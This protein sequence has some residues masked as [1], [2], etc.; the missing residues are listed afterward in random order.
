MQQVCIDTKR[1]IA[2]FVFR[3]RDL[4]QFSKFDQLRA[5]GQVPFTPR[6]DDLNVWVQRICRQL[7]PNLIVAFARCAVGHGIGA[8]KRCDFNKTFGNQRTR[9]G[10]TEQIQTFIQRIGAEHWKHE[11]AHEFFSQV[12][13]IDFR[14]THRFGLGARWLQLFALT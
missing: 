11:I 7:K 2:A 13:D 9:D 4:V 1:S 8:F 5:A 3:H 14:C 10:C 12:F 6:R